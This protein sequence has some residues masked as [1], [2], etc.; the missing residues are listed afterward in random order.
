MLWCLN[1]FIDCKVL[2][3]VFTKCPC[4]LNIVFRNY[5]DSI[6][7]QAKCDSLFSPSQ[8]SSRKQ[9][10]S[11]LLHFKDAELLHCTFFKSPKSLWHLSDKFSLD[12][13]YTLGVCFWLFKHH[14]IINH[15]YSTGILWSSQWHSC[16]NRYLQMSSH[17]GVAAI[18]LRRC[19]ACS[20][21]IQLAFGF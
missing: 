21:V 13:G 11:E 1:D 6:N 17:Q 18:V 19:K 20:I 16:L 7:L 5:Q 14:V 3:F 4:C 8:D 9:I 12:T 10:I 2:V 15:S